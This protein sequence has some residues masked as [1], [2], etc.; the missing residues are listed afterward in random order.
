[1]D[2]SQCLPT[3]L[4]IPGEM[5]RD[6]KGGWEGNDGTNT[7]HAWEIGERQKISETK[8][9]RMPAQKMPKETTELKKKKENETK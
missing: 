1:M 8:Y 6:D 2:I 3:H 5:R 4:Q 7:F 9:E